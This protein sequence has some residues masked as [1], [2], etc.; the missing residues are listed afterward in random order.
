[1]AN[2]KYQAHS[3]PGALA[4]AGASKKRKGQTLDKAEVDKPEATMRKKIGVKKKRPILERRLY[5][6]DRAQRKLLV[7]R[8]HW[9]SL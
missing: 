9:L 6:F 8:R 1:V 7:L 2:I 5:S 3:E 4:S